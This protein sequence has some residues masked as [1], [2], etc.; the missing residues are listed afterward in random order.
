MMCL[1][2][3]GLDNQSQ[4]EQLGMIRNKNKIVSGHARFKDILA[5]GHSDQ[6]K[7]RWTKQNKNRKICSDVTGFVSPDRLSLVT[8]ATSSTQS[9]G[10]QPVRPFTVPSQYPPSPTLNTETDR[11]TDRL[12]YHFSSE[13][14]LWEHLI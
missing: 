7:P 9:E 5:V 14:C 11:Q 10:N 8:P 2:D 3:P 12:C 4:N 1:L 13:I 6:K